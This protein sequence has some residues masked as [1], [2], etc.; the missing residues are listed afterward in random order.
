MELFNIYSYKPVLLNLVQQNLRS[1]K[2][3][4]MKGRMCGLYSLFIGHTHELLPDL[5]TPDIKLCKF[6]ISYSG[7]EKLFYKVISKDIIFKIHLFQITFYDYV[8]ALLNV[9]SSC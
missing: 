6:Y 5:V 2:L 1:V 3:R 9:Y 8:L 7:V 4:W